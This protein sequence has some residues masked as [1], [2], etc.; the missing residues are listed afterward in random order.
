M[1]DAGLHHLGG[2]DCDVRCCESYGA[3]HGVTMCADVRKLHADDVKR[4][5]G[6]MRVDVVVAS[7]PCQS[8]SAIGGSATS[9]HVNDTMFSEAVRIAKEL[10]AVA[11]VIENVAR[12]CHKAGPD[13]KTLSQHAVD[14]LDEAGYYAEARVI[15][16]VDYGVP[17][18]RQRA[19]VVGL[20]RSAKT[21]CFQWPEKHL[22]PART[23]GDIA[24]TDAAAAAVAD[25]CDIFMSRRKV[26]YYVARKKTHPNFVRLA[27]PSRPCHTLL[28]NYHKGRGAMALV[29]R[30]HAGAIITEVEAAADVA[31]MRMMTLIECRALQTFPRRYKLCG[32]VGVQYMQ[33]GNAIPCAMA[34]AIGCSLLDALG[35]ARAT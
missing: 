24:L 5:T 2:I 16:A 10:G 27:D 1:R 4:L 30:N 12:L 31:S 35:D 18:S 9:A 25:G 20:R 14:E 7:P 29:A 8:V 26:E 3:N 13:G 22:G 17:Q 34:T 23:F 32:P 6:G 28:A 11:I 33:L 21:L 19:I 15:D